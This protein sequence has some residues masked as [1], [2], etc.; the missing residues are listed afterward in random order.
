MGLI[1][2]RTD[3]MDAPPRSLQELAATAA[4]L[5][6]RDVVTWG[7]VWQGRQ[8]EGLSCVFLEV[9]RDFGGHWLQ[10]GDDRQAD[11]DSPEAIAAAGW[12]AGLVRSGV[13]PAAVANVSESESLQIFGAGEAA[14]MRN[15]PYAWAELQKPGSAV[16]GRVGVVSLGDGTQG[17]WGFSMLRGSDH[18]Q[19]AA[20][21]MRWFTSE[22][23]SRDLAERFGYTPVWQSLLNDPQLQERLPLLP[24]LRQALERTALRPLTPLYA[25][26]SDVLQR[27]LSGLITGTGTPQAAMAEAQRQSTLILQAAGPAA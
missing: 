27:Q 6:R 8:Y 24:V 13:T 19:Q 22:P 11:L 21:V 15:W 4:E 7:F 1:Y 5:R 12:L 17:S 2:W 23:S 20:A 16:A 14:F 25:Q 3:L 9:L 10:P 26:L 18:P